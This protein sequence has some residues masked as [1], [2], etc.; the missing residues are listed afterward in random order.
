MKKPRF[1]GVDWEMISA[2]ANG[3]AYGASGLEL[4]NLWSMGEEGYYYE[5]KGWQD[6]V[7]YLCSCEPLDENSDPINW[8]EMEWVKS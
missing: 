4:H 1:N 6:G 2:Y 8:E 5:K 3:Y 7:Q